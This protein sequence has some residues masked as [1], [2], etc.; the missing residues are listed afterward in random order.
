MEKKFLEKIR[1]ELIAKK[2]KIQHQ[3][4]QFAKKNIHVKDDYTAKF[5]NFGDKDD[6][7]A[8][9]VAIFSDN[10]SL[11]RS[12]EKTLKDIN[13]ALKRIKK[14]TYGVCL[15]CKRKINPKR[16]L[17]RPTSSSCIECKE[18]FTGK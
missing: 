15:Y 3:L 9:E 2:E 18:K 11:E 13:S 5:P 17:A 6:E 8:A 7:N 1:K 10:L 14:G 4:T 12:L 16:L